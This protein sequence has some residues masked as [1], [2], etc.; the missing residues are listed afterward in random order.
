MAKQHRVTFDCPNCGAKVPSGALACPECGSDEETG[1]SDDTM[2]DGLDL[3]IYD[4]EDGELDPAAPSWKR[5]IYILTAALLL[6][7]FF[8]FL[9]GGGRFW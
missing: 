5:G 3:P 2:Y 8:W 4:D 7:S 6:I 9:L 1:W